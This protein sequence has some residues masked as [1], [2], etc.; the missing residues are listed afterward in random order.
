VPAIPARANHTAVNYIQSAD[1]F[2]KARHHTRSRSRIGL[3]H[4]GAGPDIAPLPM[5]SAV[6]F[7]THHFSLDIP[8]FWVPVQISAFI[9]FTPIKKV[10]FY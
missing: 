2:A 1:Y 5:K 3:D 9:D 8:F 7:F 4:Q 6:P 10:L